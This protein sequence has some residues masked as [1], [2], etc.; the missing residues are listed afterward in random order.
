MTALETNEDMLMSRAGE[1]HV[2]MHAG[3]VDNETRLEFEAWLHG[4]RENKRAYREFEQVYCDLD[5]VSVAAGVN[6]DKELGRSGTNWWSHINWRTWFFDWMRSPSF[7]KGIVT[8]A[9]VA[10]LFVVVLPTFNTPSSSLDYI[11]GIA[12]I[13]EITLE[14]GSIVTLGAKSK[15]VATFSKASRQIT[16][17]SG[18]AFFEIAK[19]ADRP[20]YVSVNDT[21]VRVVGTRFNVRSSA[22]I[23]HV[24]VTEGV[25]EVMKPFELSEKVVEEQL[26]NLAKKRLIAG[27]MITAER[28]V[29]LPE[30]VQIKNSQPG[31]WRLGNLAYDDASLN[32]IIADVNRYST[33]P[34]R[35]ATSDIGRLRTTIAFKATEIEQFL[36]VISEVHSI[37]VDRSSGS[38]ILLRQEQ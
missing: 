28:R 26:R 31:S 33:R 9:A 3:E 30:V 13:R 8:I 10:V 1:W 34:I 32:E 38:Q 4:D 2:I 27:E 14:D 23:V 16:L 18:E 15:L 29:S 35:L 21:L 20:F 6:I 7:A 12:E 25:V 24:A 5:F 11:T 37:D 36:D 17:R 22:D 19:N